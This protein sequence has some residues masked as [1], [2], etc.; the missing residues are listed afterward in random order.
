MDSGGSELGTAA[1]IRLR[2]ILI[3]E[4]GDLLDAARNALLEAAVPI[5]EYI[6]ADPAAA[7]DADSAVEAAAARVAWGEQTRD[8][9]AE[10]RARMEDLHRFT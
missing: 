10:L 6:A 3:V 9:L 5:E 4:L 8:S 7:V 1:A 2:R